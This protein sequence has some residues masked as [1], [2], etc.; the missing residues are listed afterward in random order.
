MR[1]KIAV[2]LIIAFLIPMLTGCIRENANTDKRAVLV[3]SFG[4]S[5]VENKKAS[6]DMIE[7]DIAAHFADYDFYKAYT[8][9]TIIDIYEGRD[10]VQIDSVGE[11]VEKIYKAKYGELLVVPSLVINGEEYDEMMDAIEPFEDLFAKLVV[12]T[13]LLSTYEDY[14][15]VAYA[16]VQ[17]MPST[18]E[19]EAVVLMGHGTQHHANSAYGTLDYV[20]KDEGY[21]NVY[22]GTIAG[23]PT[24]ETV[25]KQLKSKGY[26][27]ITLMPCMVV[28]GDHA[29]NDMAGDEGDSWKNLLKSE[30]FDVDY[31]MKGLGEY[32]AVRKQFIDHAEKALAEY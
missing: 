12:S 22:V 13:S 29:H 23:F 9:Q 4:S 14:V 2:L 32:K 16:I 17:N 3:V 27:K 18:N 28:A 11:A 30:G 10:H 20:F 24:Y 26:E 25:L 21:E 8:A 7:A 1:R 15:N 5:F 6:L 19:N 31:I